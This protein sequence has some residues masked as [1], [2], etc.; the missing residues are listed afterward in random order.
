MGH[1]EYLTSTVCY[2][3]RVL[4]VL[5]S[6]VPHVKLRGRWRTKQNLCDHVGNDGPGH[7]IAPACSSCA[8][9]CQQGKWQSVLTC[10]N[11]VDKWARPQHFPSVLHAVTRWVTSNLSWR[12]SECVGI[13]GQAVLIYQYI[14]YMCCHRCLTVCRGGPGHPVWSSSR[15][16]S[17]TTWPL[18]SVKKPGFKRWDMR[19]TC[20]MCVSWR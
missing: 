10:H 14:F 4:W 5:S 6:G 1:R 3:C 17:S 9:F 8:A 2:G 13:D 19:C 18:S 7:D 20:T 12:R 15:F 16:L 11:Y